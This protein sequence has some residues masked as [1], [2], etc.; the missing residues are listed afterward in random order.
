[1]HTRLGYLHFQTCSSPRSISVAYHT[2]GS[3]SNSKFA[4]EAEP[5]SSPLR[6]LFVSS[7]P[8]PRLRFSYSNSTQP[9]LLTRYSLPSAPILS[10]HSSSQL[11]ASLSQPQQHTNINPTD[12]QQ[13]TC[14]CFWRLCLLAVLPS[15]A[16]ED[17]RHTYGIRIS[18]SSP[19]VLSPHCRRQG[20]PT[21]V[22]GSHRPLLSSARVVRGLA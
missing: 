5:L 1:M 3:S 12:L 16:F 13:A 15:F 21:S 22:L 14:F 10:F 2:P 4:H 9:E 7:D 8:L 6:F 11:V 17:K 20:C 18:H 19:S